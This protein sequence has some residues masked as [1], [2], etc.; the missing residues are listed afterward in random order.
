MVQ[1]TSNKM[2]NENNPNQ[3]NREK[4]QL[5][6]KIIGVKSQSDCFYF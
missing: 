5:S 6:L 1:R 3:H 4:S 2:P